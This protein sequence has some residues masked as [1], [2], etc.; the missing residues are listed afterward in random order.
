[1]DH[2]SGYLMSYQY[3]T[4]HTPDLKK[5]LSVSEFTMCTCELVL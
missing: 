5:N 4:P 2:G 1:M 3:D